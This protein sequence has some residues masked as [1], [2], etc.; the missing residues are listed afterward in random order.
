MHPAHLWLLQVSSPSS[1]RTCM[2][3]SWFLEQAIASVRV[4][5][6]TNTATRMSCLKQCSSLDFILTLF[7]YT[8]TSHNGNWTRF[9]RLFL[10]VLH[11]RI[12]W[13]SIYYSCFISWNIIL[14]YFFSPRWRKVLWSKDAFAPTVYLFTPSVDQCCFIAPQWTGLHM[15]HSQHKCWLRSCV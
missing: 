9:S 12:M 13:K 6:T 7:R 15:L 10:G 14:I 1:V 11:L 5:S 2:K 3:L 8:A 4:L